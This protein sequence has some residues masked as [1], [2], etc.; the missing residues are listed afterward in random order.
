ML[1]E[2]AD[3]VFGSRFLI[4]GERRVL[5]FW[6]ALANRLLT[7]FCNVAADLNL[8]DIETC[9]KASRKSAPPAA[10]ASW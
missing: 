1:E 6:H 8:T 9:Y 7:T 2:K 4:A 3:A 5:Y 10:P